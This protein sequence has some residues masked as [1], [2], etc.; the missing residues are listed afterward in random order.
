MPTGD[1]DFLFSNSVLEHVPLEEFDDCIRELAR[2]MRPGAVAVH[3]VDLKDHL[4]GGLNNL[5]LRQGMWE[6]GFMR[7]SG[8]YTNRLRRTA[9]LDAFA[10]AGLLV[11]RLNERRFDRLPLERR[12]MSAPWRDMDDAELMVS[13]V[14][15]VAR[16]PAGG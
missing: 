8:F 10:N 5:R 15:F 1:V 13:S 7:R 9:V 14:H 4:G 3:H 12:R 11:E 6:S 2:V 16:K